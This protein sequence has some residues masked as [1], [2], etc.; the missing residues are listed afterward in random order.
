MMPSFLPPRPTS[1]D[2]EVGSEAARLQRSSPA[3]K[4]DLDYSPVMTCKIQ[5]E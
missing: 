3:G 4:S 1:P 5:S 2:S